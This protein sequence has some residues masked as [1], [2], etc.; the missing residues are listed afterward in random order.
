MPEPTLT[1]TYDDIAGD[2]GTYLGWGAGVNNDEEP[3]TDQQEKL[4]KSF[5]KSGL[6][7]FYFPPPVLGAEAGY[8]WSFLRP[9]ATL[10]LPE[11]D[12]T[13]IL[14]DDFGG[15]EG[16]ITVTTTTS[17]SWSQVNFVGVGQVYQKAAELPDT[18]GRPEMC[19]EEPLKGTTHQRGQRFQLRFWPTSD[20]DYTLKF[21]YYVNPNCL[22]GTFPYAYGGVQHAETI[23]ES[24]LAVAEER[25]DDV[26]NGV[27]SMKFK[28]RLAASVALDQ[29]NKPQTLGLNLDRSEAQWDPRWRHW[30]TPIQVNGIVYD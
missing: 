7:N 3:W 20:D 12:S 21:T 30:Q 18:T 27:H 16:R 15:I 6:R 28:E 13:L 5:V 26:A 25:M 19:C 29:R 2:V 14:P 22:D 9:V 4:I 10:T 8:N 1:L 11:G 24:C 23:L 17:V